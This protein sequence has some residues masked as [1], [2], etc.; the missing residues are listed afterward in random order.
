MVIEFYT[1]INEQ[2]VINYNKIHRNGEMVTY[3]HIHI[4][5]L[6]MDKPACIIVNH[7]EGEPPTIIKTDKVSAV[8]P[9]Q[10]FFD[11]KCLRKEYRLRKKD[12]SL[13][14]CRISQLLPI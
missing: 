12:T 9:N 4:E 5:Q 8:L 2:Y 13:A 6:I 3:G 1:G 14:D 11:G 10:E 7:S